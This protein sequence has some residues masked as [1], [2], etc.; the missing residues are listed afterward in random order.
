MYDGIDVVKFLTDTSRKAIHY[1]W[2]TQVRRKQA[3]HT[4]AS[5]GPT[6]ID[7]YIFGEGAVDH[8]L[9]DGKVLD[10]GQNAE[11]EGDEHA[12]YGGCVQD[13]PIVLR[14]VPGQWRGG[15]VEGSTRHLREHPNIKPY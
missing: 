8:G 2:T 9:R 14:E 10:V 4:W 3:A 13:V 1:I 12:Y 7:A 11:D 6:T 15:G 5:A